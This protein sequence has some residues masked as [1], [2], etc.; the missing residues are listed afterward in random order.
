MAS[1]EIVSLNGQQE[2]IRSP[3]AGTTGLQTICNGTKNRPNQ[4]HCLHQNVRPFKLKR[5][6]EYF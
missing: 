1:A 6:F 5:Y 4:K 3:G 2:K